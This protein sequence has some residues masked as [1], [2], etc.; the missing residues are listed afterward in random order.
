MGLV[1]IQSPPVSISSVAGGT[2]YVEGT[3][4]ITAATV[5]ELD[6]TVFTQ[7]G[8]YTLFTY[9]TFNYGAYASGQDCLNAL[10]SVDAS[11]L[12]GLA[13]SG[14]LVDNVSSKTITLTIVA[15]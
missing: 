1:Y 10:V 5:I 14:G 13:P 8:I 2:Q 11:S 6:P 12:V 3:L 4:T 7:P 9:T 15:A